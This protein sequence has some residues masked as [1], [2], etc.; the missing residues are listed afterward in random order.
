MW[1]IL[2]NWLVGNAVRLAGWAAIALTVLCILFSARKSGRNT[3]RALQLKKSLEIK[4][5]QIRETMDA[6]RNRSELSRRLRN[7][8]F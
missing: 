5:A 1:I 6:P 8:K 4:D 7:G 3:E 2:K